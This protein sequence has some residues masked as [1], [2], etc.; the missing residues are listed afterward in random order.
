[1]RHTF[2]ILMLLIAGTIVSCRSTKKY[3]A[4]YSE[5]KPLFAAINELNKKPGNQK[6]QDDL[7]ILYPKAVE[8]HEEAIA[9]YKS[10]G[11]EGKWDKMLSELNALQNIYNSLQ[12]TACTFSIVTPKT[13]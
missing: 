1:M 5:D 9:I 8:R 2:T 6:A 7:R 10:G 4:S 11:D 3:Q 13:I 12:A